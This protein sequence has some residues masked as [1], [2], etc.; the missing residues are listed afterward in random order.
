MRRRI[1]LCAAAHC[2]AATVLACA[3]PAA[4]DFPAPDQ[5]PEVKDWPDPLV[6]QSGKPVTTRQ[7][8]FDARRPELK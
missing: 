7:Q 4:D 3:L 8:W 1:A 6:M 5:L 2:L